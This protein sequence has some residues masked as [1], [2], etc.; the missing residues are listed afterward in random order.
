MFRLVPGTNRSCGLNPDPLKA[1]HVINNSW[2]CPTSEGCNSGNWEAMRTA[3]ANLTAAGVLVVASA[4]NGGSACSTVN[5]P[6]AM[7]A[8]SFSV[9]AFQCRDGRPC[10]H[11]PAAGQSRS[12]AATA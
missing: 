11:L 5:D 8:E 7:F 3:V 6:P 10:Q 4:G 1:P 2:G 12:T 9:G